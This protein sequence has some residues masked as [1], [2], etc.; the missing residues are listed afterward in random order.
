MVFI[1]LHAGETINLSLSFKMEL[2]IGQFVC[3]RNENNFF[4][5][6][7]TPVGPI[8]IKMFNCSHAQWNSNNAFLEITW[9]VIF[10]SA[11]IYWNA[12]ISS[13]VFWS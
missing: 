6:L 7:V 3:N 10:I 11:N 1:L 8:A 4:S 2:G 9:K 13:S 5:L 12:D